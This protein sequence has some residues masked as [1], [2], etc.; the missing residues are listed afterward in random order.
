MLS[1]IFASLPLS[2]SAASKKAKAVSLKKSSATLKITKK[3]G[4]TKYG[5]TSIKVKKAKGV[6]IKKT[7]FK[8]LNTKVAKVSKKGK[9]TAKSRG[10]VNISVKVKYTKNK[11]TATKNLTF[12]VKVTDNRKKD[13]SFRGKL[14]AFSNKLYTISAENQKGNYVMSPAS[15]YMAMAMLYYVGDDDV[16][17]EIEELAEMNSDDFSQTGELYDSLTKEYTTQDWET[18]EKKVTGKVS[19]S[20]SIWLNDSEKFNLDM[21]KKLAETLYCESKTAPF[22]TDNQAAN[23]Q[24]REF[25]KEKT[26]GLIDRDFELSA[27]T[28]ASLV[29]TL[30]F[31]DNWE[32]SLNTKK[33]DF[34]GSDGKTA[35]RE[36]LIGEYIKGQVQENDVCEYFYARTDHGYKMKLI[37]PKDGYTLK[38]A[39]TADNLNEINTQTEFGDVDANGRE[40]RTRCLFPKFKIDA[41]TP[42]KEILSKNKYLS[43]TFEAF[44]SELTDKPLLVSDIKHTAVLDVNKDGIEGAAVTIMIMEAASIASPEQIVYHDFVLNKGFGFILTDPE[45]VVLFEGQITDP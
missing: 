35:K 21:V 2:T 10:T 7:T 26:N 14:S 18:G 29:N 30:Y 41:D 22:S 43:K 9:V 16:K 32:D 20:N 27:D 8:S 1:G 39:M 23:N 25:I 36:F 5:T 28:L 33:M 44:D 40:H 24:L 3:N 37:L 6:K 4:K 12:K 34:T 31:K 38:D 13:P 19:I 42:L 45:D 15:I 11:K 17:K